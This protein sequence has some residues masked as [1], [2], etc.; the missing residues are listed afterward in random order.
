MITLTS[1]TLVGVTRDTRPKACTGRA[2]YRDRHGATVLITDSGW[3]RRDLNIA[4]IQTG[5]A[6][7]SRGQARH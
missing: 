5:E 6:L 1:L 3:T 4:V 7:K 2:A